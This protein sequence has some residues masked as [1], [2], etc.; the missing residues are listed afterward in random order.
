MP[1]KSQSIVQLAAH[2]ARQITS[3]KSYME[4]LTTAA[5]NFKYNFRDQLLIFAQKPDATACA[6]IDFWNKCGRWVNRGTTGIALLV[7]TDRGYRLRHVFDMS[8]TNSRIGRTIPIWQMKPQYES[9]VIE[10]LENSFGILERMRDFPGYLLSVAEAVVQDNMQDYLSEL[11][12]AKA[13][14]FLEEL[15]DLNIKVRFRYLLEYSVGF[16]LLT[17]CGYDASYYYVE[18]DFE[19]I[20]DFNTPQTIAIL[21][22]AASDISEMVLREIATTVRSLYQEEQKQN[23]TFAHQ[24]DSRYNDGRTK[25]ERSVEHGTDVQS[26]ERLSTAQPGR[27]GGPEGRKIWDAAA[28]LPGQPPA[29]DL[30]RDA[31]GR[32]A[33]QP[34]GGDRPASHRDGGESDHADGTGAGRDG[35]TESVRPDE[36]GGP[37]EQHQGVGGGKGAGGVNLHQLSAPLPTEEEQQQTIQTAE[38]EKS[39]A[40]AISQEDIDA[41]LL[42]GSGFADGKYRIYE[43][44]LKNENADDNAHFLKDEYRIGGHSI[45]TS[46]KLDVWQDGKGIKIATKPDVEIVLTWKKAVK[47]ISELLA[48]DRYLSQAEKEQY[49]AYREQRAAVNA[50]RKISDEFH[51]IINDY[52]DYIHQLRKPDKIAD[53]SYLTACADAFTSGTKKMYARAMEGDFILPIM[54]DT[55]QAIIGENTHL[56]ERCETVLAELN[57]PLAAPLEP[58]ADELNQPPPSKKEYRLAQGDTVHLGMQEYQLLAFDEQTVR[59]LDPAFPI[60]NKELPRNEFDRLLAENPLNDHLSCVDKK[61]APP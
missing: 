5:H 27:T 40:F 4:F 38:D 7:D 47:R 55:M 30:H 44:F 42:Y 37:D 11:Y 54:R 46:K 28:Q 49:P 26:G 43:Q 20:Y 34:S 48:A 17:R 52:K 1:S 24:P 41:V 36:V 2:T 50:R 6:Q 61:D 58:T 13:D 15:D 51:S 39:S 16:M 32:D 9:A 59:L 33:E 57:G 60:I 21:G 10:G 22:S 45:S 35:G 14:S 29:R 56:T 31:A 25:P 23:R 53:R 18:D 3:S 8:D 19:N 12:T